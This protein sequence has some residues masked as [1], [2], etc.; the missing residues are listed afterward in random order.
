MPFSQ[1]KPC[2]RAGRAVRLAPM[3]WP[4]SL[5]AAAPLSLP[6][7]VPRSVIL[8]SRQRK[9]CWV[10][11][12]VPLPPTT[13]PCSLIAEAMLVVYVGPRVPRS[14]ITQWALAVCTGARGFD[15][16]SGP[17]TDHRHGH[18]REARNPVHHEP[19]RCS[20]SRRSSTRRILP[21]LVFGSESTNSISRGYL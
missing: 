6:P 14:A 12:A 18:Q 16:A 19:A 3:T 17:E 2:D 20:S 7:S 5:I 4:L 13:S 9:A 8:P 10:P 11:F 15:A 21:L 1:M